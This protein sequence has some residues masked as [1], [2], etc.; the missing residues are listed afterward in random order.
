M[1]AT[2]AALIAV[3]GIGCS[4]AAG[5]PQEGSEQAPLASADAGATGAAVGALGLGDASPPPSTQIVASFSA[6]KQTIKGFGASESWVPTITDAQANFFFDTTDG[7]GLSMLRLGIAPDGTLL[8]G[9][10]G[11]AQK[12]VARNPSLYVWGTPWSPPAADKTTG[13]TTTGS[14]LAAD[15][16]SW[17]SALAGFVRTAKANGIT[18]SAISAQNEPDYNT[19]GAYDMCLYDAT[20]LTAFVKALGPALGA[21]SPPVPLMMPEPSNWNDL[22]SGSSY[23]YVDTVLADSTAASYVSIL[24]THQYGVTDPPVH[25]LPAGKPLWETEMSDFSPFDPSINHAVGVASWIHYAMV[26]GGV[27]AWHYWWLVGQG[28]D[29][30]GLIGK[31]GDGSLTKHAYALGSFSRFVRPGWVRLGTT[32]SVSGLLVSAYGNPSTGAF[33]IVAINNTGSPITASFGVSGPVVAAVA[34]YVTSGSALGNIGTDGNLSRGSASASLPATIS[35]SQNAFSAVVPPGIVT[36]VSTTQA[37]AVPVPAM[38]HGA[39]LALG[40]VLAVYG[41]WVARARLRPP[42]P[43]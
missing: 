30:E 15:Y 6:Q 4:A 27:S 32:G 23:D 1:V 20:Q 11:T 3:A 38:P 29:N 21:L 12:A 43:G 41:G 36:F 31:N 35:A 40:A 7:I 39:E 13:N 5:T 25:A 22:W 28:T 24:A 2:G 10:W 37:A 14:I 19:N 42:K 18:V 17:A 34:P 26:D 8:S 33:A 9:S 16:A